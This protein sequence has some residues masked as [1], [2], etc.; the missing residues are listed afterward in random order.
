MNAH[1]RGLVASINSVWRPSTQ[2]IGQANLTAFMRTV[3]EHWQPDI[4]DYSALYHWSIER[5]EQFWQAVWEF[6]GVIASRS[7]DAVVVGLDSIAGA[8]AGNEIW[9]ISEKPA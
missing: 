5:P 3:R 8:V 9:R 6:C 2:R 1:E 4:D 7:W